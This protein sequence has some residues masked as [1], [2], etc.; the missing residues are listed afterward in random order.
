MEVPLHLGCVLQFPGSFAGQ[1]SLRDSI[2]KWR[3]GESQPRTA[4]DVLV[5]AD[6]GGSSRD[7]LE[8]RHP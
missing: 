1:C 5:A 3:R 4:K 2:A 6:N 8:G 7:Q